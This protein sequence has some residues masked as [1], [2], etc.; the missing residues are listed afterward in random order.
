MEKNSG[1]ALVGLGLRLV[2]Q[3]LDTLEHDS[4]L[5]VS[6]LIFFLFYFFGNV[7]GTNV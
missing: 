2:L 1:R 6:D 5:D 7:G 3:S 4:V